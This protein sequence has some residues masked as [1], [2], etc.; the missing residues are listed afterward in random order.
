MQLFNKLED[1]I[2]FTLTGYGKK[3][4]AEGK[5][6]PTY[7]AFSDSDIT[8]DTE[9]FPI[10]RDD[11]AYY[12][13]ATAAAESY[14]LTTTNIAAKVALKV[15]APVCSVAFWAKNW[16]GY[17][18][19]IDASDAASF[20]YLYSDAF[21]LKA[22]ICNS[23]LD[24]AI[25]SGPA[26]D[27][28][29]SSWHMFVVTCDGT[30]IKVWGDASGGIPQTMPVGTWS[31]GES[32]RLFSTTKG[33]IRNIGIWEQALTSN[34]ITDLY[35]A[36]NAHDYRLCT[37]KFPSY[38]G[39]SIPIY[40]RT[41]EATEDL[42]ENSGYM[43]DC[44]LRLYGEMSA[45]GNTWVSPKT[46]INQNRTIDDLINRDRPKVNTFPSTSENDFG[47]NFFKVGLIGTSELGNNLY[48][49]LEVK[50][51]SGHIAGSS[52]ITGT[53]LNQSIP[54]INVELQCEWDT[55]HKIFT[56]HENLLV[57]I[58]E[59]NGLFEKENFE[60]SILERYD[61]IVRQSP[62][63]VFTFVPD[64]LLNF[65][66]HANDVDGNFPPLSIS[67]ESITKDEVEYWFDIDIDEKIEESIGFDNSNTSNIYLRAENTENRP[68]AC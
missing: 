26:V 13:I 15:T 58:T 45:I 16:N 67:E 17:G 46:L 38:A 32:V 18:M 65:M 48:P 41:T 54:T 43:G 68:G 20:L 49:A 8:Y 31:L 51:H 5:F 52:Y 35:N 62:I 2:D 22:V 59:I 44:D 36:G 42:V 9:Y 33:D 57:E 66:N 55:E 60:Y 61:P 56:S 23:A 10:Y 21:K 11:S 63:P 28:A 40:W 64:R 14:A 19:R 25:A 3:K 34:D 1:V 47:P 27:P 30:D 50:L 39:K 4:L 37:G 12:T 29:D 53:F 7:Y 24:T 6:D